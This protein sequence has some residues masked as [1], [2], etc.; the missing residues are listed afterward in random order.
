MLEGW[1]PAYGKVKNNDKKEHP[2]LVAY[3]LLDEENK[4]KNRKL[5]SQLGY[6][7]LAAHNLKKT[8]SKWWNDKLQVNGFGWMYVFLH[9]MD[10][11]LLFILS[12]VI[13]S[14]F[15]CF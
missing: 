3:N 4:A 11:V 1:V 6:L 9:L 7:S 10:Y 15:V 13:A 5:V 2:A 12:M 8:R 14:H